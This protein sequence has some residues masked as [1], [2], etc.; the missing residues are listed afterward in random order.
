MNSF[1]LSLIAGMLSG[2]DTTSLPSGVPQLTYATY[3]GT[4]GGSSLSG[5]TI[6][7]SGFAYI[8]GSGPTGALGKSCGFL[9]KLNQNGTAAIWSARS[10][11]EARKLDGLI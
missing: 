9:T 3:V 6:D 10:G 5:L 4:G 2:L 1:T 8:A 7:S 11:A